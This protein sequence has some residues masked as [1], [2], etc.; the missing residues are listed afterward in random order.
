MLFLIYIIQ[1]VYCSE[2]TDAIKDFFK[3][4][5]D[6]LTE[7]FK[8]NPQLKKLLTIVI[9][10]VICALLLIIIILIIIICV[11]KSKYVKL[12]KRATRLLDR[13][14]LNQH[15]HLQDKNTKIN[16]SDDII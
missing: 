14:Q 5:I 1:Q 8:N 4:N 3:G 7:T 11:C 10:T 12:E 13:T 9:V 15:A 16:S 2:F 6:K